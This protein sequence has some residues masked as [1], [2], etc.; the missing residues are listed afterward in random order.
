MLTFILAGTIPCLPLDV[1][2]HESAF[3]QSE[4]RQAVGSRARVRPLKFLKRGT[5]SMEHKGI[6][7]QVVQTQG[8][9]CGLDDSL[10]YWVS[11][12]CRSFPFLDSAQSWG[13]TH[14]WLSRANLSQ[15]RR[16]QAEGYSNTQRTRHRSVAGEA[17]G[18]HAEACRGKVKPPP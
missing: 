4:D 2:L 15:R 12:F 3:H 18:F 16:S 7:Y 8:L 11:A 1:G 6:Q 10:F 13:R 9:R 17:A 5:D 14:P